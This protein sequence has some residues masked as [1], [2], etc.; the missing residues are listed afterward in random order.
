MH[1]CTIVGSLLTS[2]HV[3]TIV[4][5]RYVSILGSKVHRS[6]S[7]FVPQIQ[8]DLRGTKEHLQGQDVPI[9][10]G[11]VQGGVVV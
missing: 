2:M 4:G 3:C 6:L 1:V 5:S 9:L 7:Q 10:G 11:N 8:L